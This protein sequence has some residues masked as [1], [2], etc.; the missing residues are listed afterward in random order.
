MLRSVELHWCTS[1]AVNSIISIQEEVLEYSGD[2]GFKVHVYPPELDSISS[3]KGHSDQATTCY[4]ALHPSLKGVTGKF[5]NDCNEHEPSRLAQDGDLAR[6]LWD[7]SN[8]LI[9]A[10]LRTRL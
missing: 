10:D 6:N 8:N 2:E 5:F 9:D 7:F 3:P 4:V 1:S